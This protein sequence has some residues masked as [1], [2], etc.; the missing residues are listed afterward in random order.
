MSW[1]K[2]N[3]GVGMKAVVKRDPMMLELEDRRRLVN[4]IFLAKLD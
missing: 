2:L 4:L 3:S 1:E